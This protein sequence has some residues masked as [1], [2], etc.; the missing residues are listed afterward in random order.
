MSTEKLKNEP[1]SVLQEV[2]R[3]G[4]LPHCKEV[5]E[6]DNVVMLRDGSLQY[7]DG[8]DEKV[9]Q[10]RRRRKQLVLGLN[11]FE[12]HAL[13]EANQIISSARSRPIERLSDFFHRRKV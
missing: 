5:V 11:G 7:A 8:K 9:V 3:D 10:L 12:Q 4:A 6:Q 2:C 13:D 1:T